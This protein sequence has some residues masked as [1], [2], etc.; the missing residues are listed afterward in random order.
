MNFTLPFQ[1]IL[2]LQYNITIRYIFEEVV[3]KVKVKEGLQF[4]KRIFSD[5]RMF[6]QKRNRN[7]QL[8]YLTP[9]LQSE[10]YI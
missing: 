9:K 8:F 7:L 3:K 10:S 5:K 4:L 1:Y 6:I 2:I